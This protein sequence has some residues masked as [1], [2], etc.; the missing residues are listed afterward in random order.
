MGR[1][2]R[3]RGVPGSN[4]SRKETNTANM[5]SITEL[6]KAVDQWL[7]RGGAGMQWSVQRER[8]IKKKIR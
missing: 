3:P 4:K 5:R 7:E 1:M 6:L 2:A 8:E